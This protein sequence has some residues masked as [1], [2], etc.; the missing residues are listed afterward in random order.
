MRLFLDL[1]LFIIMTLTFFIVI[2]E[3]S[4]RSGCIKIYHAKNCWLSAILLSLLF[5]LPIWWLLRHQLGLP[6]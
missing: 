1:L 5:Y 2:E 3:I 6:I 4:Y